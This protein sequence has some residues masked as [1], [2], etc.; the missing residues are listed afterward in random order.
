MKDLVS[1]HEFAVLGYNA[2]THEFT[3]RNP[4]GAA[5][6]SSGNGTFEQ[7]IDQLWGGTATTSN[8]NGFFIATGNSP[9]LATA[10]GLG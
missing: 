7:T 4:W 1:G 8:A 6:G 10:K 3:L 2:T 9:G 5:Q